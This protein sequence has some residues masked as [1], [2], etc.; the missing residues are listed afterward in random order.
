MS[1]DR[2]KP[3]ILCVDD[4]ALQQKLIILLLSPQG[5]E[6]KTVP[7]GHCGIACAQTWRPD[8]ILMDLM[9]PH[10]DGFQA[11][12]VIKADPRTRHIPIIAYSADIGADTLDRV[13]A[14]GMEDLLS[15]ATPPSELIASLLSYLPVSIG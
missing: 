4:N 13:K 5:V 12:G 8:L 9:M 14:A 2:P 15:K 1:P 10:M 3:K 11:A 7:N 6:V